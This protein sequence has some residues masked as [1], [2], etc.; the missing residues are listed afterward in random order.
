MLRGQ[1]VALQLRCDERMLA[2]VVLHPFLCSNQLARNV[3]N[4]S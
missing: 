3:R 1:P 4:S 2:T